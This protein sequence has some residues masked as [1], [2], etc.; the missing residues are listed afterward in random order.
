MI[1]AESAP[2]L[3]RLDIKGHGPAKRLL[4]LVRRPLEKLVGLDELNDLYHQVRHCTGTNASHDHF[5]ENVLRRLHT[6]AKLSPD[7]LANIPATGPLVVVANHP[8]G[9]IEGILLA[10]LLKSV[11]SDVKVMANYLLDRVPE[12]R[13]LFIFVDPFGG[14]HAL[15]KNV[16]GIRESLKWLD[17][18]GVLVIFPAGTVS[19]LD[20][21]RR[22]ITDPEWSDSIGSIVR[23]SEA[24]V[25]PVFFEGSNGALFQLAGL[26]HPKLRTAML[27]R[28]FLNKR[29]N[30][31]NIHVGRAIGF[32]K[33]K[34]FKEDG[35]LTE[36]LRRRT[37]LLRYRNEPQKNRP[38][39]SQPGRLPTAD[40]DDPYEPIV[41]EV[42]P[43]L[44]RKDIAALP[45]N[46]LLVECGDLRVYLATAPRLSNVLREIGRLREITFRS[47]GEGTG[48]SIDLDEF[49]DYY[50]HLFVWNEKA[51][52]VVSAYRLGETDRILA[53]R[54]IHGLY[55]STLFKFKPAIIGKLNP[56]L[57][58]GRS[59]VRPEYQR[60]FSPLML[61]WK[62]I[63]AVLVR[64]PQY[65]I[66]FGPVSISNSYNAKSRRLMISFLQMQNM[67]PDLANLVKAKNPMVFKKVSGFSCGDLGEVSELVSQIESDQKGIPVLIKHYLK[68][69]G[70]MLCFNLDPSFSDVVDGLVYVDL[71]QTDRRLLE[72]YMGQ[73]GLAEFSSHA[74]TGLRPTPYVR[75]IGWRQRLIAASR[76]RH[77]DRPTILNRIHPELPSAQPV[78]R[79]ALFPVKW[80]HRKNTNATQYILTNSD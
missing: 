59:F 80:V 16:R 54:G 26:V 60:N 9:A 17:R 25:V 27:P 29:R 69:G 37:Y 55:T 50:L 58:L 51:G 48:K 68:L 24:S 3:F 74:P 40:R 45:A 20:V 15:Q 44:L 8:F 28:E 66:L 12:L 61:L 75:Q 33:L 4:S 64:N 41:D 57:E 22:E 6:R 35:E 11:R 63:A 76:H 46:D 43:A 52:Q 1:G 13:D 53:E 79:A 70:Q 72:K 19:H 10:S 34:A 56:A 78:K 30:T 14:P 23:R 73:Q 21:R 31:L 32:N 65:R 49:D 7:D 38:A 18:G 62:G 71:D 5:L 39:A 36:H 77:H 42:D 2:R 47:I 67:L